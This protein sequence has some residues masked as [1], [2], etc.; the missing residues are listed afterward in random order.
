MHMKSPCEP[1]VRLLEAVKKPG[2]RR[3]GPGNLPPE[4][5]GEI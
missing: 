4:A 3:L 1:F 2:I 5:G